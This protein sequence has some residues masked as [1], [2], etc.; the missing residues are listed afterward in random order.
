MRKERNLMKSLTSLGLSVGEAIQ[1]VSHPAVTKAQS[2]SDIL[3]GLVDASDRPE[4]GDLIVYWNN[5]EKDSR[6]ANWDP[7]LMGFLR[8]VYPGQP[9]TVKR[10]IFNVIT[11]LDLS[12]TSSLYFITGP[13]QA[14]IKRN[15]ALRFGLV[16]IT[17]TEDGTLEQPSKQSEK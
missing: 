12:Q 10:N 13:M 15:Y 3:D 14:L 2:E 16:P 9:I 7:S 8:P 4:G 6:Y 17:E 1:V 5:I 11:A